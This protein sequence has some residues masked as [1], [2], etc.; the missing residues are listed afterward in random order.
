MRKLLAGVFLILLAAGVWFGARWFAH[1]GEI[2]A[3]IVFDD[4]RGLRRGDPVLENGAVVGRVTRVDRLDDRSAVTVRLAREH[5]RAIVT[6]SLFTIENDG[7]VVSNT[8]AVG[9]PV[10]DGAIL[11]AREDRVSRW[12]AKHGASVKPLLDGARAKA[13]A[14][15]DAHAF[16]D[17]NSSVPR[18]KKEG[19]AAFEKHIEEVRA[20]VDRTAAELKKRGKEGEARKLEERFQSWLREVTAD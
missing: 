16:D 14:F 20:K 15:I 5:R 4:S 18:W 13:D 2:K 12:L 9:S 6:D 3:T 19:K 1:R 8:F 7:L 11:R 10:E 17:W